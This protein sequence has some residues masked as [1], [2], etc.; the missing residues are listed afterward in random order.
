MNDNEHAAPPPKHVPG[1]RRATLAVVLSVAA[2]GFSIYGLASQV[3][4]VTGEV[5]SSIQSPPVEVAMVNNRLEAMESRQGQFVEDVAKIMAKMDEIAKTPLAAA[6]PLGEEP[7]G[8]MDDLRRKLA[9]LERSHTAMQADFASMMQKKAGILSDLSLTQSIR[10]KLQEG[11]AF[12]SERRRLSTTDLLPELDS[13]NPAQVSDRVLRDDLRDLA[14][15]FT[16]TEKLEKAEGFFPK[17][18]LRVQTLVTVRPRDGIAQDSDTGKNLALLEGAVM[19]HDWKGAMAGANVVAPKA[20]P[21]FAGWQNRLRARADAEVVLDRL[22]DTA[23]AS[24][25]GKGE[26]IPSAF[27]SQDDLGPPPPV[28]VAKPVSAKSA[29][30]KEQPKEKDIEEEVSP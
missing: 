3:L 20:P 15:K 21:E 22:E 1:T 8:P 19:R 6:V 16:Q 27:P 25:R 2:L 17:L 24:L 23:L 28:P 14:P 12:S 10:R 30:P 29:P 18:W 7:K 26:E 9:D 13:L 4:N 5:V 11:M